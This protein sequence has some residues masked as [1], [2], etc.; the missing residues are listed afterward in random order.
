MRSHECVYQRECWCGRKPED[1]TNGISEHKHYNK[2]LMREFS[3]YAE[4]DRYAA[5]KNLACIGNEPLE[6]VF[7][8]EK[9]DMKPIIVEGLKKYKYLRDRK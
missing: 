4:G 8:P 7:K 1:F 3:T 5:K 9:Q 2:T 6:K